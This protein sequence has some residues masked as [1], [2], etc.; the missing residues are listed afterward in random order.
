M[1]GTGPRGPKAP[2]LI[3]VGRPDWVRAP[4]PPNRAGGSPAHGSPVDGSPLRGL[5]G[6]GTGGYQTE[7]PM[8]DK[9]GVCQP[10]FTP[11]SRAVN[12]RLVQTLGSTHGQWSRIS[13]ACLAPGDD[14]LGTVVDCSSGRLSI[15]TSIFLEPFARPALPGFFARMAPLTSAQRRLVPGSSLCFMYRSF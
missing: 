14:P 9:E 8:F 15:P 2:R 6:R 13:S 1:N 10:P 4:L 12:M 3:G 5:N 7:Q 11:C